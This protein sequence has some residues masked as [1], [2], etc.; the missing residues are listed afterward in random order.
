MISKTLCGED[1]AQANGPVR[2]L[3]IQFNM[4]HRFSKRNRAT[5]TQNEYRARVIEGANGTHGVYRAGEK[6]SC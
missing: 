2:R 1:P 6:T 4:W 3:I 5:A